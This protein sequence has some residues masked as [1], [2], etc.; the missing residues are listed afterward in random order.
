[1][2]EIKFRAK[3]FDNRWAYG[4]Y[5]KNNLGI[6][7]E[8]RHVI[9]NEK[10][11]Y[12]I[13]SNTLCQYTGLKDKNGVEIYEDDNIVADGMVGYISYSNGFWIIVEQYGTST[14]GSYAQKDLEVIGNIHDKK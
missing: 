10:G 3:E 4:Y 13:D 8:E 2:R 12:F 5:V 9:I 14:L 7:L 1:M 6:F 11:T